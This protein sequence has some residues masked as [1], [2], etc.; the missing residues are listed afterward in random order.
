VLDHGIT[1]TLDTGYTY[2]RKGRESYGNF[3]PANPGR[4]P[5]ESPVTFHTDEHTSCEGMMI[6]AEG[7][8]SP[9]DAIMIYL[10]LVPVYCREDPFAGTRGH[11]T[12]RHVMRRASPVLFLTDKD[13]TLPYEPVHP[14]LR[15][16]AGDA[17]S[18]L[19]I[20]DGKKTTIERE[21]PHQAQV[22]A[23]ALKHAGHNNL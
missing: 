14:V 12:D 10:D 6:P 20:S 9:A 22:L 5:Q 16:A 3:A 23:P 15:S 1:I 2:S 8:T 7:C 13:T 17:G 11:R 18:V 19:D 4:F 21:L